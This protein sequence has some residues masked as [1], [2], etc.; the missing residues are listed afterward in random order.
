MLHLD[1]STNRFVLLVATTS[2][3]TVL[4]LFGVIIYRL[5]FHAYAKYPGPLLAK[6]TSWYSVYHTYIGDL[7][8]DI[9]K[10]HEKYGN[11]VRYAPNRL[12]INT[13]Q[14]LRS[15][16]SHGRNVRKSKSYHRISLVKGVEA[17]QSVVNQQ[18]HAKLR[19]ILSQ[20]LSD[21]YLRSFATE[22]QAVAAILC[23]RLG[24]TQDG[25][26]GDDEWTSP[27]NMA[28]WC[29]YFTFD[30]M[31]RLVFGS[32][33]DMLSSAENRWIVGAIEGQLR[34]ISFLNQLPEAE[35]LGLHRLLFPNARRRALGL[36]RKSKAMMEARTSDKP[37]TQNH[38]RADLLSVLLAAKDPETGESLSQAQLWAES[39]LLI[40]AGSDT[41][42]TALAATFF[43]LT[44]HPRAYQR[45]TREVRSACRSAGGVAQGVE[46][47]SCVYLRA[48]ITEAM[49]LSPPA[50]GALWREVLPGGITIGDMYIPEGYD[51][52]TGIYALHHNAEYFPEPFAFR[53]E[54]WM[55]EEVGKE[56]VARASAAN[57][58]FSIGPRNCVGKS[59]AMIEMCMAMAS[60]ICEFD[61]RA[62]KGK[63]GRV[64]E[65]SGA[66]EGQ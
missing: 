57:T 30:V 37:T 15:I 31:S 28:H 27:K 11:V 59:F 53:P 62:T 44:R 56:A 6:I 34:R 38:P 4:A 20:G 48:C 13:E 51:V 23:E 49:R 12:L 26:V 50:S 19:R 39:N 5:Y 55:P 2:I 45:A 8:T 40:I 29:D 21:S 16:Y 33:Y 43:Y 1:S 42:S 10:C 61:F 36:S 47:A 63:E 22:I 14:G 3:S 46:L 7:H 58:T 35:D 18:V 66:F 32:S 54:R 41:T 52:G 9:W 60:V 64:G 25:Y 65:G 17:T 24:E